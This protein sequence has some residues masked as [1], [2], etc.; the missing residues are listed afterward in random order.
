[1]GKDM[2]PNALLEDWLPHIPIG[3]ALDIGAGDGS[4]SLWLANAGFQVDVIERDPESCMRLREIIE[5]AS[6]DVHAIDIMDYELS[7]DVY[8]LIYAGA[9]LHFLKP[10]DLWTLAD[11][12]VS[13]LMIGGFLIAQVFTTDDP[14]FAELK[15]RGADQIEPNTFLTHELKGLIH[16]FTP[17]ELTRTFASLE[18]LLDEEVRYLDQE[19]PIGFR[20][21]EQIVAR[22][23]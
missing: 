19:D 21:G 7:E 14:G 13:S 9:V 10:T 4:N 18:I 22:K 12:M 3:R 6:I 2:A 5:H 20:S 16:Y 23:G 8:A 1:M 17:G 11:R 15:S